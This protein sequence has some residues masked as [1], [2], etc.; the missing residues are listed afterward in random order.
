MFAE[1]RITEKC[2]QSGVSNDFFWGVSK[3]TCVMNNRWPPLVNAICVLFLY[4]KVL[5]LDLVLSPVLRCS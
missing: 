4:K 2:Q 1:L 5:K 3:C